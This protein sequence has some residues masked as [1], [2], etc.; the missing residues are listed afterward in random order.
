M[1]AGFTLIEAI[2][3]NN[4]VPGPS[5]VVKAQSR[6]LFENCRVTNDSCFTMGYSPLL[7]GK[8]K[9]VSKGLNNSEQHIVMKGGLWKQ[10]LTEHWLQLFAQD[11]V[12][13]LHQTITNMSAHTHTHTNMHTSICRQLTYFLLFSGSGTYIM[14]QNRIFGSGGRSTFFR[15]T[16]FRLRILNLFFF[17]R[18]GKQVEQSQKDK[19][20]NERRK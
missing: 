9:S 20:Q 8:A 2:K 7:N 11:I 18:C 13:E 17:G 6:W 5:Q 10:P 4:T 14:K 19:G 15:Y 1:E 12:S 16:P 3:T